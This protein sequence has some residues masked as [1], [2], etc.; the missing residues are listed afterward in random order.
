[1]KSIFAVLGVKRP[2][3]LGRKIAELY[4][5]DHILVQPG[6][7]LIASSGT[8]QSLSDKLGITDASVSAALVVTVAGYFGRKPPTL[9]EWIKTKWGQEANA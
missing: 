5:D 7:W 4:P 6:E 3:A 2:A 1:M 9:W 8:A